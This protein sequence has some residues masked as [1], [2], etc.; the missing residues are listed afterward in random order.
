MERLFRSE[1]CQ[2][3]GTDDVVRRHH[4]TAGLSILECQFQLK[5]WRALFVF[6]SRG[7]EAEAGGK[8]KQGGGFG[9]GGGGGLFGNSEGVENGGERGR[10]KLFS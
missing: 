4:A 8:Q 2:A 1:V 3:I 6:H 9:G 5:R 10:R 7:H